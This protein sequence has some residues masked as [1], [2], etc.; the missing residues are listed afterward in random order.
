MRSE[1]LYKGV[2]F[3]LAENEVDPAPDVLLPAQ[4]AVLVLVHAG[5]GQLNNVRVVVTKATHGCRHFRLV[6]VVVAVVVE[7]LQG[8][9]SFKSS[10]PS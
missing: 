7:H 1:G 10:S 6:D 2:V 4:Q 8:K 3:I 9:Q 5:E